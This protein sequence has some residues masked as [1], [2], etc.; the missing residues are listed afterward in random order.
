[1]LANSLFSVLGVIVMFVILTKF[2]YLYL[3][4]NTV[5]QKILYK[6]CE[7]HLS[8][9]R[10]T[11]LFIPVVSFK[12][13]CRISSY[14]QFNIKCINNGELILKVYINWSTRALVDNLSLS[15]EPFVKYVISLVLSVCAR[16]L[17]YVSSCQSSLWFHHTSMTI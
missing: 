12:N 7:L 17:S 16:Q 10:I 5:T 15:H 9:K 3:Y 4:L 8:G 14:L 6:Y 2:V 11:S 13:G 1:M